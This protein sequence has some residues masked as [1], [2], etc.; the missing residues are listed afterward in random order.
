LLIR[1]AISDLITAE[2]AGRMQKA[3]PTLRIVE[4]ARIGHAPMLTEP[5]A[6]EGISCFLNMVA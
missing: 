4:V 3:A 6:T 2:I 5:A 1:G